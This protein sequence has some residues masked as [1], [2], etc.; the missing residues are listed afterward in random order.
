M[1][2]ENAAGTGTVMREH[3]V[4]GYAEQAGF[5]NCEVGPIENDFWRFNLL[6]P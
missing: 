1:V 6:M 2:G 4:R 3:T 5:A